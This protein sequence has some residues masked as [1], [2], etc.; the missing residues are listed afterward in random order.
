MIYPVI[1]FLI[2]ALMVISDE[3]YKEI[4][5]KKYMYLLN[6]TAILFIFININ[7]VYLNYGKVNIND[8]KK[9]SDAIKEIQSTIP[10]GKTSL[11]RA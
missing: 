3:L 5:N 7:N 1:P 8:V 9:V 6:G 2:I 4:I 10:R 11:R